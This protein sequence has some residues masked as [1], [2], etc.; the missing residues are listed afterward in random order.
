MTSFKY[1]LLLFSVL[2]LLFSC[3]QKNEKNG[4]YLKIKQEIDTLFYGANASSDADSLLP[5]L[6]KYKSN[7][8]VQNDSVMTADVYYGIGWLNAMKG[9]MDSAKFYVETAMERVENTKGNLRL[10]ARIYQGMGNIW[11][12][13]AK[14]HQASYYYN[15]AAGIYMSD[16]TV[17]ASPKV[18]LGALLAAA[19]SNTDFYQYD[20]AH[21]M[22]KK[23]LQLSKEL[24]EGHR[25]RQR[26]LTQIIQTFAKQ[27][28]T[29]SIPPYLK[30]L[31][32]I[33]QLHPE[34]YDVMYLYNCKALYFNLT[35]QLDSL[36]NYQL[37]SNQLDK[38]SYDENPTEQ[39]SINNLLNS[40]LNVAGAYTQMDKV[41]EASDYIKLAEDLIQ[42]NE[43][44]ITF[45]RLIM[46]K[47]N[48]ASLYE[49]KGDY[50]RALEFMNEAY[51]LRKEG[52]ETENM[53]AVAEMNALYQLQAKDRSIQSLNENIKINKLELQQNKL[54]LAIAAL[55][56]VLLLTFLVFF[57]Y[58]VRQRRNRQEKEKVLLQQ[59]LLRTQMEPH[60]IF[61]TL[62]ALQ[63]FVRFDKK[64][65]A[66]KYLNQFSRLLRSSL[67]LSRENLVPL[68]E[69]IEALR[70]YLSLQQ[71]RF[72]G[73][74]TYEFQLPEEQDLDAFMVPPMLIQPYVENAILHGIELD[75]TGNISIQFILKDETLQVNI[76]DTG[77]KE[78]ESIPI[79]HR[80]LSGTIS[81]ERFQL[82]G[83]NA[84]IQTLKNSNGGTTVVLNIP[85]S[86]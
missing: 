84:S 8:I 56:M 72:E 77:K 10:K 27:K 9:N 13:K 7:P 60:F 80:S 17:K 42:K 14:Q 66:L 41:G 73:A 57:Y 22:N 50:K 85:V 83:K 36:L 68:G 26:P 54:W 18:K 3:S 4:E 40:Y 62:G 15:K 24:P 65:N 35:E 19:Q 20:L 74:F 86:D 67:E 25:Y 47:S 44:I 6:Y 33:H 52:F 55:L 38:A 70:N 39:V 64:E 12:D 53:Q 30:K 2:L 11:Y 79:S 61:N 48:A 32:R 78:V 31:E 16:S 63:S 29:D 58:T 76:A 51:D 45:D 49:Q 75:N 81:S 34:S 82:L 21:K 28:L 43:D 5:I 46:Y 71:M 69:E 59:Q 1:I 23:A 37:L